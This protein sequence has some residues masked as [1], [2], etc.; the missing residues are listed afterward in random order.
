[1][2]KDNL[3]PPYFWEYFWGSILEIY[4]H[5]YYTISKEYPDFKDQIESETY[6]QKCDTIGN[7]FSKN[8]HNTMK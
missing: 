2:K 3:I 1:M 8:K 4:C 7:F 5:G 6:K